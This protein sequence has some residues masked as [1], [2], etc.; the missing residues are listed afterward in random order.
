MLNI[1]KL[2]VFLFL[3]FLVLFSA[4]FFTG[5][6]PAEYVYRPE[7]H[8]AAEAGKGKDEALYS[9]P[10]NA[11]EGKVRI[12]SMGVV[13][14][15]PKQDP[16]K[17]SALHLRMSITNQSTTEPWI[18]NVQDQFVSYP[19]EGQAKPLIMDPSASNVASVG[20]GELK[21]FDYYFP[22]PKEKM[23][24]DNLPEFD[25]HWQID[26]GSNRVQETTSFNR[27]QIQQRYATGY[28]P[29]YDPW[30]YPGPYWGWGPGW[31]G[32]GVVVVRPR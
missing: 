22:L 28:G 2:P 15:K 10:Q 32:G 4:S 19:N 17:F 5:C 30:F 9:E 27:I 14:V 16:K 21:T 24:A 7:E 6:S 18:F 1:Q 3:Y 20:P 13:D 8:Q 31:R 11:P 23:S 26:A 25:F 29:Y 12:L